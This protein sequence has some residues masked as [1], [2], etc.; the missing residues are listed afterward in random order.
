M[1]Q[2]II[3]KIKNSQL[4]TSPFPHFVV[5]NLIPLKELNKLNKILPDFDE[6][7]DE[8][9]YFQSKSKT[10][11]TLLPSSKQYKKLKINKSFKQLNLIFKKIKFIV[12][13]KFERAIKNH[14]NKKY[15]SLK[16]DF[17][18]TYNV[19]TSGYKKSAHLDRRDHLVHMLYYPKTDNNKGGNIQIFSLKNKKKFFDIFPNYKDLK[20]EKTYKIKNNFC[21]FTLNV[22][23]SYHGVTKYYGKNRKYFYAVYDFISQSN[24]IKLKHR[25]KGNNE[26]NFW[27]NKVLV[28]S[29]KRKQNF[30]TE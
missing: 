25:L 15:K 5:K 10:K 26:N 18:S 1:Y 22:P 19:M 6:V 3:K 4:R 9:I 23:W 8:A 20:I 11:K 12:L 7:Y 21:L 16:F 24:G 30:F 27:H 29:K 28:F 14:V 2:S 13:K 17:H